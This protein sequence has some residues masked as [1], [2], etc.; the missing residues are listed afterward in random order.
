MHALV[1]TLSKKFNLGLARQY[2]RNENILQPD[3]CLSYRPL[4]EKT[5]ALY[6]CGPFTSIG[7]I[8]A[9][10]CFIFI[11]ETGCAPVPV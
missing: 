7:S 8:G 3:A 11:G 6:G 10:I 5:G 9:L 4:F 2:R 1:N